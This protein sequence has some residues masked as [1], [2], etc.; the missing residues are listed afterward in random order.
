MLMVHAPG[1]T[2][3]LQHT[4]AIY[5]S[6]LNDVYP[7]LPLT[8]AAGRKVLDDS[9]D[10]EP[11]ASYEAPTPSPAVA[12]QV[13]SAA[14]GVFCVAG[15]NSNRLGPAR[16]GRRRTN[17]QQKTEMDKHTALTAAPI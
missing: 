17:K 15:D 9:D 3:Q 10:D 4:N 2:L 12:R 11:T 13:C 8:Y 1:R 5:K 14:G 6:A 7:W 16:A